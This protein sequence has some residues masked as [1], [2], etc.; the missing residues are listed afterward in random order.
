MKLM[1][2]LCN[3]RC[4][5]CIEKTVKC[6]MKTDDTQWFFLDFFLPSDNSVKCD[7]NTSMHKLFRILRKSSHQNKIITSLNFCS[8]QAIRESLLIACTFWLLSRSRLLN[9]IKKNIREAIL[10]RK[11]AKKLLCTISHQNR[12]KKVFQPYVHSG[13]KKRYQ[14]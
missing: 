11:S 14:Q 5:H 6:H 13:D 3:P 9:A 1:I 4:N 8:L 2:Y 10:T 12:N 7:K